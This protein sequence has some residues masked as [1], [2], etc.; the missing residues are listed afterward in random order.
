M[1]SKK[2]VKSNNKVH[3]MDLTPLIDV[4]FLLLI[5]FMVATTFNEFSSMNIDLPKSKVEGNINKEIEK[6][7][8]LVDMNKNITIRIE[9]SG[10]SPEDIK[11]TEKNLKEKLKNILT[12]SSEKGVNL[13]AHKELDYGYIVTIIG[14]IKDSGASGLNIE[15][16]K[17]L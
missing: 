4:V 3:L 14:E 13:V 1:K 9:K 11:T 16:E 5:F 6:I 17:E 12:K 2:F 10:R 8:I 7:M 15:I